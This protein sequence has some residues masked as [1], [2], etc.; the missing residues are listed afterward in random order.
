MPTKSKSSTPNSSADVQLLC[1]ADHPAQPVAWL[2]PQR[3]PL[4]KVTLLAGDPG[5][6]KSLLALDIAARVTGGLPFPEA[7]ANFASSATTN[8][9]SPPNHSAC[10]FAT[11]NSNLPPSPLPLPP[12]Q[13]P[14]SVLILSIS[15]DFADTIRPRLDAAGADPGASS[16]SPQSPTFATTSPNSRPPS[17]ASPTAG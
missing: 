9:T 15:D 17:T 14:G 4:G 16:P 13:L 2:W 7:P 11:S 12:S 1:A 8:T 6:G 3:I 10:V 5:L